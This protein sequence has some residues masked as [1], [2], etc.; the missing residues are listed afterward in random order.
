MKQQESETVSKPNDPKINSIILEWMNSSSPASFAEDNNLI[1]S[2]NKIQVYV[3]LDNAESISNIPQDIDVVDSDDNIAVA[4]VSSEQINQLAQLDFVEQI[5]PPIRA[6]I[7]PIPISTEDSEID[8]S[9]LIGIVIGIGI[10]IAIIA[11]IV[12]S[13]KRRVITS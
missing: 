12:Y 10:A 3:Y 7:P 9:A 6:T 13:K 4:L 2:D 11:G 1:F 5:A 8:N